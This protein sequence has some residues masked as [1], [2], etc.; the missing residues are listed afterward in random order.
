VDPQQAIKQ[1]LERH[2]ITNYKID[3]ATGVVDVD[4]DVDLDIDTITKLPVKFGVVSGSFDIGGS[5]LDTLE[6]CPKIVG[7]TFNCSYTEI[8]SFAGGPEQ[9]GA[10]YIAEG[11][12][13]LTTLKGLPRVVPT[14]LNLSGTSRITNLEGIS[15]RIGTLHLPAS[16][17]TAHNIHKMVKYV[18]SAIDFTD[19][20]NSSNWLG[21]LFIEGLKDGIMLD[22]HNQEVLD[23]FNDI[24]QTR[25]TVRGLPRTTATSEKEPLPYRDVL[26]LQEKLIDMGY[27]HLAKT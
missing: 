15:E 26:A 5:M 3:P 27:S 16:K 20:R 13:Q 21:I 1:W 12:T 9:V 11:L 7:R 4:G 17:F 6:G 23:A 22:T 25:K 2:D 10:G 14:V 19:A 8:T 18:R 24:L